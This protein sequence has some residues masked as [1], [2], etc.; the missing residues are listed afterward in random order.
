MRPP[1]TAF[2]Y[3]LLLRV[4]SNAWSCTSAAT[5]RWKQERGRMF[6]HVRSPPPACMMDSASGASRESSAVMSSEAGST[7]GCRILRFFSSRE[8][9]TSRALPFLAAAA[10]MHSSCRKSATCTS[11]QSVVHSSQIDG[12]LVQTSLCA[13]WRFGSSSRARATRNERDLCFQ[14]PSTQHVENVFT[15]GR[16]SP[17]IRKLWIVTIK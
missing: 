3:L 12:V 13:G 1:A 15:Q 4:S 16:Q 7:V 9:R 14:L 2:M 17:W 10:A 6:N 8:Q 11:H 5:A